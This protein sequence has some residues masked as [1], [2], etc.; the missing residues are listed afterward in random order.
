MDIRIIN[1]THNNLKNI[2]LNI[3]KNNIVVVCG[4]SGSG[5]STLAYDI[6][7]S[8]G[9]RRYIEALSNY[10][11]QF[12]NK[13]E[14]PK[15]EKIE[16]LSPTI[17]VDQR[18]K[19]INPRS[20]VGTTTEVYDYLRLV[21]ATVGIPFCP[22]C[23]I[24]ISKFEP[25]QVSDNI[26]NDFCGK[27]VI[28]LCPL[29]RRKKGDHGLLI[30][31]VR[32]LGF[33]KLLINKI[34]VDIDDEI[35]LNKNEKHDID[36]VID[37]M[38]VNKETR[39]RL[40]MSVVLALDTS[41]RLGRYNHKVVK[42]LC[43]DVESYYSG[44]FA[45]VEC[46]F[47][48]PEISW[49]LFSFNT[50]LGACH[51]CRGIGSVVDFE[52]GNVMDFSLSI[53]EGAIKFLGK[54]NF[55]YN[56]PKLTQWWLKIRD[57]C[58]AYGIDFN[59]SLKYYSKDLIDMLV[60]GDGVFEGLKSFLSDLYFNYDFD[61]ENVVIERPCS[62][63]SGYRLNREAL[64]VKVK[65]ADKM[66]NIG[67]LCSMNIEELYNLFCNIEL[68]DKQLVIAGGLVEEVKNRLKF[69]LDIGL[70]Y[71][72]L[73][74]TVGSLSTGEAQRVKIASLL[75]SYVSG[76]V[77]ILDEPTVG[78]HPHNVDSIIGAIKRLKQMDN[79]VIVVEHDSSVIKNADYFV[80]LGYDG[81]SNGGY[82]IN[83]DYIEN[84]NNSET[85]DYVYH[86]KKVKWIDK[87]Y[88]ES[89]SER[90][91][92]FR[93]IN[94]NNLKD[95]GVDIPLNRFVVITGVSGS[96]K[97]S[98]LKAIYYNLVGR[99]NNDFYGR[100]EGD[101]SG[102]VYL[103]D[104]KPIGKTPRSCLATYTKVFDEIRKIF[105]NL[106]ESKR[107]GFSPSKFSFNLSEG[108]CDKCKGEGFIKVDMNFLPDVYVKCEACDGKRYSFDTL[109]VKFN[110]Y[111]IADILDLTVDE[112][113]TVF[114]GFP[115]VVNRLKFISDIG[116]GYM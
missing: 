65:F 34:K 115:G 101:F 48:Y 91:L 30:D 35:V 63:C 1:A 113:I 89:Y 95:V 93:G 114:E 52:I 46:G 105:A 73:Y 8:E 88:I 12:L 15:V 82:L 26:F 25:H 110:G 51:K 40:D 31:K 112:C 100:F 3:P 41:V 50:P 18:V 103:V 116:L 24:P 80:E 92:M 17:C 106:P 7:Y 55:S 107:R 47:S 64:S 98:L 5:K 90:F 75:S 44:S 76:V 86:R 68:S 4:V 72:N 57:F 62:E 96:G 28:L 59:R 70:W 45:C 83:A 19:S 109:N 11:R 60:N 87:D 9:Q 32:K 42:V 43:D 37:I 33:T 23:D 27:R 71:L 102:D 36:V 81:G 14:K 6:I 22:N 84:V 78:L 29:V 13:L 20:T 66:L 79:T 97:T 94:V 111:S 16:G 10:A 58:S 74:R 54:P 77:Y 108:R 69:L 38:S 56:W 39:G 85:L 99:G 21:F 67:Q 104:Q 61:F 2:S 53:S 49:R